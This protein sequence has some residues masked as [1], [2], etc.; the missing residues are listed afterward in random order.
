MTF[1]LWDGEFTC[2]FYCLSFMIPLDVG[3][4]TYQPSDSLLTSP[5]PFF[6]FSSFSSSHSFHTCSACTLMASKLH[7]IT[8]PTA[9]DFVYISDKTYTRKEILD[10]EATICNALKFNLNFV[11]PYQYVDRFLRASYASSESSTLLSSTMNGAVSGANNATNVLMKKLVFYLLDLAVLEYKLVSKKP[12]LVAAAAVYLARATLGVR[13]PPSKPFQSS[14][15]PAL[16]RALNG[17][18]SKTLEYYTGY[19]I[20]DLEE[21]VRLLH[22]LQENAEDSHLTSIFSKHKGIKCKRVALKTVVNEEELGFL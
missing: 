20:W 1:S 11:T 14:Y 17:F 15:S 12:S 5:F 3:A 6:A 8:P 22:R 10:M 9:E 21:C 4:Q 19:D 7:E 16:Q 18:W 2:V 13:E